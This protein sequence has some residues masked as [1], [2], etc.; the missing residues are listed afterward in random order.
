MWRP[1][2]QCWICVYGFG[3]GTIGR[4]P[5]A[6]LRRVAGSARVGLRSPRARGPAQTTQQEIESPCPPEA[7]LDPRAD[8]P[9][10]LLDAGRSACGSASA[11]SAPSST[12][13]RICRRSS[14]WKSRS[15]RPRSKFS[16][17]HCQPLA[18][19]GDMAGEV[20]SLKELPAYVPKA[21]VAIEDRRFYR[22]LRRRSLR[23]RPR[24]WSPIFCIAAWRKAAPPS[25]NSSPRIYF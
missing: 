12:S 2:C 15:V 24:G 21:F 9:N 1:A 25:R 17:S 11:A 7:P 23:H 3:T 22:S 19:R 20:L 18:R 8:R 16:M 5:R 14:R 10:G 13:A 6:A 4:P